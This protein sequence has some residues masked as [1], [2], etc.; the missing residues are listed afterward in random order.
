MRQTCYTVNPRFRTGNFWKQSEHTIGLG[1]KREALGVNLKETE[2]RMLSR[3]IR[4]DYRV[5]VEILL[6]KIEKADAVGT[7]Q[8]SHGLLSSRA[9]RGT[10]PNSH[11]PPGVVDPPSPLQKLHWSNGLNSHRISS[12]HVMAPYIAEV[13]GCIDRMK[14]KKAPGKDY[15]PIEA[16]QASQ[17]DADALSELLIDTW[18]SETLAAEMATSTML[19]LHKKGSKKT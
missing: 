18:K 13:H 12:R 3:S 6:G 15:I 8:L 9:K 17:A 11:N 7:M 2:R 14:W 10:T 19:M 16:F 4:A 1:R 5:Y